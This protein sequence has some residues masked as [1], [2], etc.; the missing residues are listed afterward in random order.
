MRPALTISTS[1]I[2]PELSVGKGDSLNLVKPFPS[3]KKSWS[4]TVK[5]KPG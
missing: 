5:S 3:P 4:A 1:K 2:T